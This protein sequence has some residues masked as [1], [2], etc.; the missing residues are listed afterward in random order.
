MS[1]TTTNLNGD[2]K[3]RRPHASRGWRRPPGSRLVF[4]LPWPG[5]TYN[6]ASGHMKAEQEYNENGRWMG[7][8][9]SARMAAC[10]G[11][12]R[13]EKGST[14]LTKTMSCRC[15]CSIKLHLSIGCCCNRTTA[16]DRI[17][18][19]MENV[20]G[21]RAWNEERPWR[22]RSGCAGTYAWDR[23]RGSN[24]KKPQRHEK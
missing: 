17:G 15:R 23:S 10:V 24:D 8:R 22:R 20:A 13:C 18:K 1:S 12:R 2:G 4:F 14:K 3:G 9:R 6:R 11:Q 21:P 5:S 7:K 19:K 16:C